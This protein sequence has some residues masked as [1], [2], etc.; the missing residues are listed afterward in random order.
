MLLIREQ[1]LKNLD[2]EKL[3]DLRN[4]RDLLIKE[5]SDNIQKVV[6]SGFVE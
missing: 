3:N 1:V 5:I 4:D 6:N 2:I